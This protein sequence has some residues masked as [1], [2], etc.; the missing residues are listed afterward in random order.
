LNLQEILKWVFYNKGRYRSFDERFEGKEISFTHKTLSA[1][2]SLLEDEMTFPIEVEKYKSFP[3]YN[4]KEETYLQYILDIDLIPEDLELSSLELRKYYNKPTFES[5]LKNLYHRK[6][7]LSAPKW[8]R[9]MLNKKVKLNGK[10]SLNFYLK[11]GNLNDI[12]VLE[13]CYVRDGSRYW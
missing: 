10:K 9:K 3:V 2:M 13:A 8:Y 7:S 5:T 11:N 4:K 12:S 1:L 6:T